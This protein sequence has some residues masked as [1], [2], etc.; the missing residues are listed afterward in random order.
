[1]LH[2]YVLAFQETV[3]STLLVCPA[4][5]LRTRSILVTVYVSCAILVCRPV[6]LWLCLCLCLSVVAAEEV[7]NEKVVCYQRVMAEAQ[8]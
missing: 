6:W 2:F 5:S 4:L 7:L 3:L 1:M 8:H